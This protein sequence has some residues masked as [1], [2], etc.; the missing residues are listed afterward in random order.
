MFFGQA[1]LHTYL[2]VPEIEGAMVQG[3]QNV[4]YIDQ[5]LYTWRGFG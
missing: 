1:L 3:F 2:A 5:V 4:Q